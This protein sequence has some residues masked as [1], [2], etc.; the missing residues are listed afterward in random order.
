MTTRLVP[1]PCP[2]C[3]RVMDAATGISPEGVDM[4]PDPGDFSLC[5]YCGEFLI[6][7]KDLLLRKPT[8]DELIT[9][10]SHP[11]AQMVRQAWVS[12]KQYKE[13]EN[14]DRV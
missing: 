4:M 13:R 1:S 9:V 8:D 2:Y 10:G 6:Y 5:S 12:W 3:C 11:D 14:E 7:D